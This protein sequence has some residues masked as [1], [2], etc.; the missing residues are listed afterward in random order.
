MDNILTMMII[1]SFGWSPLRAIIFISKLLHSPRS[2][3]IYDKC[4][5]YSMPSTIAKSSHSYC[6]QIHMQRRLLAVSTG[7]HCESEHRTNNEQA[8]KK[9]KKKQAKETPLSTYTWVELKMHVVVHKTEA[10][11]KS[12]EKIYCMDFG[13]VELSC[14]AL[15]WHHGDG[16]CF[17]LLLSLLLLLALLAA[18]C[19]CRTK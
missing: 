6:K 2:Q 1:W 16:R 8:K 13:C 4:E 10:N 11:Q 17:Q 18:G 12:I 5:P 7:A 14:V 19:C 15:E 9:R 3:R